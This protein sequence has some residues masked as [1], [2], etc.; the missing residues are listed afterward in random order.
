M[1]NPYFALTVVSAN[2]P[3]RVFVKHAASHWLWWVQPN[4]KSKL[5]RVK[6][7][8]RIQYKLERKTNRKSPQQSAKLPSLLVQPH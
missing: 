8:S 7:V 2:D 3:V 4:L 1:S 6:E 5:F